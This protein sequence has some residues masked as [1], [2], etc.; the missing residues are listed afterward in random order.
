MTYKTDETF[1]AYVFLYN[2]ELSQEHYDA[3]KENKESYIKYLIEK[4]LKKQL[5]KDVKLTI[6]E[7]SR[8]VLDVILGR[9]TFFD[10]N[11]LFLKRSLKDFE[12][13]CLPYQELQSDLLECQTSIN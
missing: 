1:K 6:K 4:D 13:G 9:N 3:F 11:I 8:S 5:V 12:D 10:R 7:N 2:G